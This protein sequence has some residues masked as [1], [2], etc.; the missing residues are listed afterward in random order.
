MPF[1]D[2]WLG[3]D[4]PQESEAPTPSAPTGDSYP[5]TENLILGTSKVAQHVPTKPY[6]AVVEA[7][8]EADQLV[9]LDRVNT[10]RVPPAASTA[11][12]GGTLVVVPIGAEERAHIEFERSAEEGLPF[13]PP[14][15]LRRPEIVKYKV[16]WTCERE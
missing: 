4:E 16:W 9:T 10:D 6:T 11:V 12:E 14:P 5:L 3:S 1:W 15:H 2:R 13:R 8:D 7:Y